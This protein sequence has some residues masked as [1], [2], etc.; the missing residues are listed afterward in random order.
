[1]CDG[2]VSV[3]FCTGSCLT[4]CRYYGNDEN[5]FVALVAK[6]LLAGLSTDRCIRIP[7]ICDC[8]RRF[9]LSEP[10]IWILGALPSTGF[11]FI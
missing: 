8:G 11:G 7:V 10:I 1:V 9:L 5:A 3:C 6:Q 2:S 4:A